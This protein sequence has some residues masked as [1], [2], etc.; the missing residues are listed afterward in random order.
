V[1]AATVSLV[2]ALTLLPGPARAR[3]NVTMWFWG[4]TPDYRRALE[5]ALVKPF[6]ASQDKYTLVIEYRRS[7]D[8]DV[9]V[10][11]IGGGGP[12]LIYT[13]GPSDVLT[14]A[15]AGNLAPL[16]DY[17]TTMGW[18]DR[19]QEPLMAS[20]RVGGHLYCLPLSREVD[21]LFYNKAVLKQHGW[22]VPTTLAQ[23]ETIM[24]QA[25]A[26]GLYASVTGNRLWQPVNENYSTIFLNQFVGPYDMA[27]LVAGKSLWT[28]PRV[29]QSMVELKR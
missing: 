4:A 25:Q 29:I 2:A 21:G 20:C 10:A 1:S 28:S 19:L 14:L 22:T 13:S 5:D 15:H 17:A 7:V 11:S 16:D 18:N 6:N 3:K 26:A 9:R 8:N 12:D 23:A 27:C 24:V